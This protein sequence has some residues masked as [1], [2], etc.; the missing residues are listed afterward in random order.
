MTPNIINQCSN[1]VTIELFNIQF[2][3]EEKM[4]RIIILW[5]FS[6]SARHSLDYSSA[7]GR[8]GSLQAYVRQFWGIWYNSTFIKIHK[9]LFQRFS[10]RDQA[11]FTASNSNQGGTLVE[12]CPGSTLQPSGTL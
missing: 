9:A 12:L 7:I 6:E 2:K 5:L 8:Q 3:V 4:S 1:Q 10:V 11:T